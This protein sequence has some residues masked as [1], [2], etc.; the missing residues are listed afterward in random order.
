LKTDEF[1]E[2]Q[3]FK[4]RI[5]ER[6]CDLS[7]NGERLIYFAANHKKPY[8]S[9]TAV[10]RP[11]FLTALALWPKGDAWG[12]GGLF[13]SEN[14]IQLNHR[15]SEMEVADDFKLPVNINVTSFGVCSG[16]GEDSPIW[17]T[18]LQ[19]DGWRNVQDGKVL[20]GSTPSAVY[21]TFD[22][23]QVWGKQNPRS[24]KQYELQM[25]IHGLH[26]REGPWYVME[27]LVTDEGAPIFTLTETDWADWC[28][29][30]DLLFAKGGKLFRLKCSPR[31][32]LAELV[33][34]KELIDLRDRKFKQVTSP[35]EAK[36]WKGK[37][38]V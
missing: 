1:S 15:A 21:W 23:P 38:R 19:R 32:G 6:R 16:W 5:Y 9:W 20:E 13:T 11:P 36:Q 26:Q 12:G 8:F 28:P 7:P 4:G 27:Y 10:S 24:P 3:W 18:Q 31:R 29:S 33:K 2:G 34:A 35:I 30:G 17:E 25:H 22:P 37:L 14:K